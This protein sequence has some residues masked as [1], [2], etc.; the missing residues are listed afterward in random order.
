MSDPYDLHPKK[1]A[2]DLLLNALTR[3]LRFFLPPEE[4]YWGGDCSDM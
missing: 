4:K 2:G 3:I 1:Q